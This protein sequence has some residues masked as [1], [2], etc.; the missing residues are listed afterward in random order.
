M[1][2][3][4]QFSFCK[5]NIIYFVNTISHIDIIYIIIMLLRHDLHYVIIYYTIIKCR[6]L[7][8]LN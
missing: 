7:I 8:L 1:F 2:M 4:Q 5:I 6:F 3:L